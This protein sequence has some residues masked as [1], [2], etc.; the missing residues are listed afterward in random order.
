ME[1]RVLISCD[2]DSQPFAEAELKGMFS[3]LPPVQ[4]LDGEPGQ[5]SGVGVVASPMEFSAFSEKVIAA[6]SIFLRHLAPAPITVLL[7]NDDTDLPT[8]SAAVTNLLPQIDPTQTISVQSRMLGEFFRPFS[9]IELNQALFEIVATTGAVLDARAPQQVVSVTC[10]RDAAYLGISPSAENRSLWPG[11]QMR[12]RREEGQI[13]R[14]EFKLLEAISIFDVMIPD[15]GA[16]LDIGAAP[17]GWTNV[18]R[19]FGLR[20]VAVDPADMHVSLLGDRQ[21]VHIRERIQRYRPT[22]PFDMIVN[23]LK[24]DARDSI[25]VMLG[26]RRHLKP[27]GTGVMT[28]KLPK[29]VPSSRAMLEFV[30]GDVR[31]LE[32]GFQVLGARQ[33]FHNRSEITVALGV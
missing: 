33:L 23:D 3:Q 1:N 26:V 10:A 16:A 22:E 32:A 24:M 6:N 21:V 27:G 29:T 7:R 30:R 12:F 2:E 18:L 28:L 14:A 15:R 20:V 8:L 31:R 11:G 25:E 5:P 19:R 9:R 13:S 17:G 4:W